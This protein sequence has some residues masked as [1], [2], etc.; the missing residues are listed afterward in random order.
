MVLAIAIQ[1]ACR[2]GA[3]KDLTGF[4]DGSV[5]RVSCLP[6]EAFTGQTFYRLATAVT[7]GH[8]E[9]AQVELAS[10]AVARF[11]LTTD[12]LAFDTTNF[13]THI[14]TTTMGELAQRGHA[15]SKRSDLRVVGLAILASETG[16]V[17]LLYRSYSGNAADQ[18]V[19]T[20]CLAGLRQL[21]ESLDAKHQGQRRKAERTLVRDGGSWSEQ[22][23]L[24]LDA[25]GYHTIISLP[26]GHGAAEAALQAAA[27]RGAM[28]PLSGRLADVRAARLRTKVGDLDRTLI[29]VE[30]KELLEGQKRGISVALV[31]AKKELAKLERRCAAGRIDRGVLEARVA[32]LLAREHL[33]RFVIT[34]IGGNQTAPTLRWRVDLVKRRE[35]ER[36]RLGKRVLCTDRHAWSSER[37]VHGFRG[38]WQVEEI[39]RRAKKGGVVPWGPSYQW[40]DSSLRLHTFATVVGLTLVSLAKLALGTKRSARGM[41]S[42]LSGIKATLVRTTTGRMGRRPTWMLAP[43]LTTEQRRAVERFELERWMP[44]L[45]SARTSRA[46]GAVISTADRASAAP[47]LRKSG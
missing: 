2:P 38:Q 35:L 47:R 14:A 19:L 13:D 24:D 23:E 16:H 20:A 36:L 12:V 21:H 3:K 42:E 15:K 37:I 30:S 27:G 46:R 39:F 25:A 31:K 34:D 17:P 41:M 9:Q 40:A 33:S 8:L 4:L 32:R 22:L 11:D 18:T 29:V 43:D 10:A 5:P 28:K 44:G 45:L 26:L 6:S 1:R 7:D